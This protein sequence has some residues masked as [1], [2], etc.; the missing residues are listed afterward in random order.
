MKERNLLNGPMDCLENR[1]MSKVLFFGIVHVFG[2]LLIE[3]FDEKI[4]IECEW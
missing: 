3:D 2:F 1:D 4:I